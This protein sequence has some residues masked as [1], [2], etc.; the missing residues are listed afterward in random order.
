MGT[1]CFLSR[2]EAAVYLDGRG[3]RVAKQT[4]PNTQSQE[5]ARSIEV[6]VTRHLQPRRSRCLGQTKLSKPRRSTS[7]AA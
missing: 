7:E 5:V 4:S 6:R 1:T 3:L 2:S